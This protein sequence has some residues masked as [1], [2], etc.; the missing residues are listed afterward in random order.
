MSLP[1][2]I[3][4]ETRSASDTCKKRRENT[5]TSPHPKD[6]D[7]TASVPLLSSTDLLYPPS[8]IVGLGWSERTRSEEPPSMF[9][10]T[11]SNRVSQAVYYM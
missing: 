10:F 7:D 3:S 4:Q 2:L 6:N 1:C 11:G 8:G 9:G 5:S